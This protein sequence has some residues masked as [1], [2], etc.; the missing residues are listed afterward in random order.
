[1]N[2][3]P[4]KH[5][6]R[7]V[8]VALAIPLLVAS[9]LCL[10]F[11]DIKMDRAITKKTTDFS[12]LSA[13][14]DHDMQAMDDLL[15]A[16][17]IMYD[18]HAPQPANHAFTK[19]INQYEHY[20][21]SQIAHFNGEIVGKGQFSYSEQALSR[22]QKVMSLAPSFNTALALLSSLHSVAYVDERGFA[23]L[24]R[25]NN[26]Q[27]YILTQVL[28]GDFKPLPSANKLTSSAV[29][30]VDN[31]AYFAVGRQREFNSSDYI[32]L[33]YDLQATSS[34]LKKITSKQGEYVFINQ[35]NEI[36][37]SSQQP[38]N[39]AIKL[40]TYWPNIKSPSQKSNA[41]ADSL[42]LIQPSK[43]NPIHLAFLA[44]KHT[45]SS[46]IVYEVLIE[47]ISLALFLCLMFYI[48]FW[49][50]KRIFIKP[51]T[52][53]MRYLEHHNDDN[54][55]YLNY[56]IPLNWQPWFARVKAIFAKN[57]HLVISLQNANQKLD[58]QVRQQSQKLKHSDQAKERHLALLN[59]VLNSVPDFIYFKNTEGIFLGCN[60]AFELFI[61]KTQGE[62]LGQQIH[63][64]S[65]EYEQISLLEYQVL[66]HKMQIQQRIDVAERTYQLTIAP[67]Y[68]EQQ[69]LLGTMGVGRDITEQQHTLYALKESESIF[70][71]AIE[72]AA[73]GVFLLSLEYAI[74][75]VN[76]AAR[77]LFS[78]HDKLTDTPFY[79]LFNNTQ[80]KKLEALLQQ[81]LNNKKRVF[82][83]T[84]AH[85]QLNAW[86][87]LSMSL[88]WNENSQPLYYVIHIQDVTELTKAKDDAERATLAKSRF[89]ANLSHE[90]RTPLNAVL[91][92]L[93]ML[94]EH[95]LTQR[96]IQQ[97]SQAKYAANNLLQML[98][99][100]LDFARV[101][102]KEAT[103]QLAPLCL[104]DLIDTCES[105]ILPL[106]QTKQI[107]LKIDID[108]Q[109]SPFLVGDT[110]RLQ[111]VLGN[112]LT[113]AVKFT[114]KGSVTLKMTL[115]PSQGD[116]E[117]R[118]C[119][120][121]IDTGVGIAQADQRRLFDAFTQGD[122]SSTRLH[123]GVGL[124]LAIV[125]H[126][127]ALMGGEIALSSDKGH[128]CHFYFTLDLA[129]DTEKS[130]SFTDRLLLITSAKSQ[131]LNQVITAHPFFNNQALEIVVTDPDCLQQAHTI[132]IDADD[133]PAFLTSAIK[134]VLHTRTTS[135]I[136]IEHSQPSQLSINDSF[137]SQYLPRSALAQ[138]LLSLTP[139]KLKKVTQYKADKPQ[140]EIAGTL[141]LAI[142]DNPLNLDII[143][144]ILCKAEVNVVTASDAKQGV[145]WVNILRPDLVLM[146]I[147][148]P[149]I[150]GYQATQIIRQQFDAQQLPIFAL[151]AHCEPADIARSLNSGM[152][153]HLTKP[154]V[155]PILLASIADLGI[156]KPCFF[157][158]TFA[159][160]Q[161]NNDE[162]LLQSM[163]TKLAVLNESYS[164]ELQK[165]IPTIEMVRLVHSL[166]GIAG[167]LGFNRLLLC[168][169]HTEQLLKVGD[170]NANAA[171]KE[172]I[173]QLKQ[174]HIFIK[175]LD[176]SN[177]K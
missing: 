8:F 139:E 32:V 49:L 85:T 48:F 163:L 56:Q 126:S 87:Q 20:Y 159:L 11:Y 102:S 90:I 52:E 39:Q 78:K 127:V 146:D 9:F 104:V 176:V 38:I 177:D 145:E 12:A 114:N 134:A 149:G 21:Y 143:S 172:L 105:L 152:N 124:G 164:A 121:V 167:N 88:I 29:I 169:Q 150:D 129:T 84:L 162:K 125:K 61:G 154:V 22:W 7:S 28:N 128:G 4:L 140:E 141:V 160:T 59:T 103:L 64:I 118:I 166:K 131:L 138:R 91:G 83:L 35:E 168:A 68:N 71:S 17:F 106:C 156:S 73:N 93:D 42:F 112:L 92:L 30:K 101:E 40:S 24:A 1:M 165:D 115:Q 72:F 151:T 81:L 161:F 69:Q 80:W 13:Q 123:Q 55:G 74:L 2:F 67:F 108:S 36:I 148:M 100:M 14:L 132:V 26:T 137:I 75:Q 120:Q 46:G 43:K 47:F 41:R 50:S 76:K 171:I 157:D 33:I 86:L 110:I 147:Q 58:D 98:N 133:V 122:E 19:N 44:D 153:K 5:Y 158:K 31:N 16:M 96:Q 107:Q 53:L 111:Q 155:A 174:V 3:L 37:A 57:E 144:S 117:Q 136:V 34:W 95:G 97:T 63:N 10:H 116:K 18:K 77:K 15:N 173:I 135:L 70:R 66:Q 170:K 62:L 94:A 130:A 23:Y 6:H 89:I 51:M 65:N 175:I 142:D 45:L 82:H 60:K 27:S 79:A 109:I 54:S 119:F 113:N 99:S 25:R